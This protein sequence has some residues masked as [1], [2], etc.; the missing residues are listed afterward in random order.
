MNE[1]RFAHSSFIERNVNFRNSIQSTKR[2]AKKDPRQSRDWRFP[3][4]VPEWSDPHTPN[5]E[6][7]SLLFPLNHDRF[8]RPRRQRAEARARVTHSPSFAAV[9]LC[10]RARSRSRRRLR[11]GSSISVAGADKRANLISSGRC[12]AALRAFSTLIVSC[13]G[14]LGCENDLEHGSPISMTSPTSGRSRASPTDMEGCDVG[15]AR[16][17]HLAVVA[18]IFATVGSLLGKLAGGADASSLVS[19]AADS[20]RRQRD[21]VDFRYEFKNQLIL[22]LYLNLVFWRN[23]F[24]YQG[25]YN[26]INIYHYYISTL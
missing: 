10:D 8:V 20:N 6:E 11:G 9:P 4:K 14:S 1:K 19:L 7:F 15:G 5:R 18:G 3:I 21:E 2:N 24:N 16:G 17:A 13:L 22:S 12:G 26:I 23:K 25:I